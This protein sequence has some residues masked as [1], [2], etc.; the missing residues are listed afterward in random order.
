MFPYE[1]EKYADERSRSGATFIRTLVVFDPAVVPFDNADRSIAWKKK[2]MSSCKLV[3]IR[4]HRH[5]Y[6]TANRE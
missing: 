3:G 2:T 6:R 4:L 1:A 5:N